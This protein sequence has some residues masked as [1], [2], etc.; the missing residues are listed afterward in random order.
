[1][2]ALHGPHKV[3]SLKYFIKNEIPT[4]CASF[5]SSVF[6]KTYSCSNIFCKSRV[7]NRFGANIITYM[8]FPIYD[9]ACYLCIIIYLSICIQD[10]DYQ[11]CIVSFKG[12]L[13][14]LREETLSEAICYYSV[15][16][17]D[18]MIGLHEKR[19]H[20]RITTQ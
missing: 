6:P 19:M 3:I 4:Y 12:Y 9:K 15:L 18:E 10:M 2:A 5:P 16:L 14:S 8:L 13:P 11:F 20:D 1:M 17:K 7:Q